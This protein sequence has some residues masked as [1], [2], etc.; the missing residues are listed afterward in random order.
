MAQSNGLV[1][2]GTLVKMIINVMFGPE[3]TKF[4]VAKMACA[5]ALGLDHI[6]QVGDR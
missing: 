6:W 4:L 3:A 1:S 5:K 2:V